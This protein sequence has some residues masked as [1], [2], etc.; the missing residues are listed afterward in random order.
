MG[1]EGLI[2]HV[3]GAGQTVD[4]GHQELTGSV[5]WYGEVE[6]FHQSVFEDDTVGEVEELTGLEQ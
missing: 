2:G 4:L 6:L 5:Q 3:E 1:P